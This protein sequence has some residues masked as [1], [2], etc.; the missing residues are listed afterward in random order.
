MTDIKFSWAMTV[1]IIA[2]LIFGFVSF[3]SLNFLLRADIR[4]SIMGAL[5]ISILL[6]FMAFVIKQI[7]LV[8]RNF[9]KYAF[10]EIIALSIYF[11]VAFIFSIHP[12]S[13]YFTVSNRKD[14]IKAKISSNVDRSIKMF[15]EYDNYV[16]NSLALYQ[17][18]LNTAIRGKLEN[19]DAYSA[20]GLSN[21]EDIS[22]QT[23]RLSRIFKDYLKPA[24][25][26]STKIYATNWLTHAKTTST[27]WNPI[28]LMNVIIRIDLVVSGWHS[29]LVGYSRSNPEVPGSE[30]HYSPSI[31]SVDSELTERDSP[32]FTAIITALILN[33]AI[34]FPY[35]FTYRND[36]HAGLLKE[37]IN[38]EARDAGIGKGL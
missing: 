33:L 5:A 20:I 11:L 27:Y 4:L 26:D 21:D 32:S 13:H 34:L 23:S 22:I 28:S 25:Y 29:Q 9:R 12:Y 15:V 8:K 2:S 17:S 7:K 3:L 36:R 1:S 6:W 30:F 31:A 14:I 35:F 16:N 37:L 19:P 10:V 38:S 24:G 18:K